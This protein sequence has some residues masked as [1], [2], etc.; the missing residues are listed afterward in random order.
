MVRTRQQARRE[1]PS[2]PV[3]S[4][5][6]D[7]PQRLR[8]PLQ[9]AADVSGA[10]GVGGDQ[11]S[12]AGGSF[13]ELRRRGG[14]VPRVIPKN[15]LN[16]LNKP[17]R[18]NRKNCKCC[19]DFEED[20]TYVRNSYTGKIEEL[21]NERNC[22][23]NCATENLV[24]LLECRKCGIR[25][26]GETALSLSR[27]FND[28]RSKIRNHSDD[29]RETFLINHFNTGP[30][31]GAE[32]KCS[33]LQTID[34]PAKVNG[35]IDPVTKKYRRKMEDTWMV[36]LHTVYPY[37]LNNRFG[38]NKDQ[39]DLEE[40]V[41]VDFNRRRSKKKRRQR[42]KRRRKTGF[43]LAEDV[44][45]EL[46]Y[47]FTLPTLSDTQDINKAV[48]EALKVIPQLRKSEVKKIGELALE[49]LYNDTNIPSRVLHVISD[50]SRA[51][52]C[53]YM[54]TPKTKK[55]NQEKK[56][57]CVVR[58]MNHGTGMIN[59]GSI[60]RKEDIN[61]TLPRSM[62]KEETPRLVYKY[63]PTIRSK[64]FNYRQTAED[65][66]ED[67]EVNMTCTCIESQFIDVNH[68]HVV[69]GNLDIIDN[70]ELRN[71][72]QKG[73][74]YREKKAI[75]W[76]F[77]EEALLQ[78]LNAF[79]KKWSSKNGLSER[80]FSEW[81]QQVVDRV[82]DKVRR[83]KKA[84]RYEKVRSVFKDCA[85]ELEDLKKKYVIVPI[86]KASNNIGFVCK[87]Y[88]LQVLKQEVSSGTYEIYEET[89][90]EVVEFLKRE[91]QKIA[92]PVGKPFKDLPSIHMTLKM[93]KN[94]VKF[95]FI[96]GSRTAV[97]K[98][99][100]KALVQIL[101]F[102]MDMHRRYCAKVKFF[103]GVERFWIIENNMKLLDI[104]YRI[105]MKK[106]ARNFEGFDFS[107]LYTKIS[108]ADLKEKLKAVVAKAFKGGSNQYIRVTD[109]SA[110]WSNSPSGGSSRTYSKDHVNML[111]DFVVD[112]SF[113][114]FGE[115]V[116]R[117][118]VGIPMG[119]DPAPQ[120]AN[121]YLYFYESMFMEQ[122]TKTDYK[123]AMKFNNTTRFIDDLGTLN[124]DGLMARYKAD[125]Y[126]RELEL[127]SQ[128]PD[129]QKGNMLDVSIEV[130]D[131]KFFTKTYD[132]RDD[133]SFEIINYPDLSGN[134]PQGA[135][136]GVYISQVLR[137]AR[138]CSEKKDFDQRV[139]TLTGKLIKKGYTKERLKKTLHRCYQKY[140]WIPTKYRS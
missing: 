121:L 96:I 41:H 102:V 140:S 84:S 8:N 83:L 128:N 13:V 99:A 118:C 91:S 61:E 111:I 72:F 67:S 7:S 125:I 129:T 75:N 32:Y 22:V 92:M 76:R 88:Y 114:R 31:T 44:Y 109:K 122:L 87:K 27:R 131:R 24:Y 49:D 98:P 138:V 2:R 97:V 30:C 48:S 73:P 3:A 5:G 85:K 45:K 34:K 4:L 20:S 127:L 58:Y 123:T 136:Y 107:T 62:M 71:I 66:I 1:Q 130:L 113:F 59:L 77:T 112:N 53:N 63:T 115:T 80:C 101:K 100:A 70:K 81:K 50:L 19:M 126:P 42:G 119:V 133:Y 105:S 104:M 12:D 117:Q 95:R 108:L 134:I 25:Y 56:I 38:K 93:H 116:Y 132:K 135:A 33:I 78:D 52:L 37:G 17:K 65:Y 64:I 86:D 74:S 89:P 28:H 57:A 139:K 137:Y 11:V 40:A 68:G 39:K 47:K 10:N 79:I 21:I 55:K 29:Q 120:M 94:P 16:Q 35:K 46:V 43:A 14:E 110:C 18:C 124:N 103:T 9:A 6:V 106:R 51:K 69:T 23:I 26:V 36:K 15:K 82:K 90:E 60:L 54:K